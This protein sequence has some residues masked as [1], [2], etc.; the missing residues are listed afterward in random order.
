MYWVMK[1]KWDENEWIDEWMNEWKESPEMTPDTG[2]LESHWYFQI[3]ILIFLLKVI[4]SNSM[5]KLKRYPRW[6]VA[7]KRR[8]DQQGLDSSFLF[9]WLEKSEKVTANHVYVAYLMLWFYVRCVMCANG[10][11]VSVWCKSANFVFIV[12]SCTLQNTV[13][14]GR[15]TK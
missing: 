3:A 2:K 12:Y 6:E 13:W 7:M 11:C 15:V 8:G 14:I 4:I 10:M 5:G 1:W 9:F